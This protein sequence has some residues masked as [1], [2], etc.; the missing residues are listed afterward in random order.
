[1]TLLLSCMIG[2]LFTDWFDSWD[3]ATR[4]PSVNQWAFAPAP[5]KDWSKPDAGGL[6][7]PTRATA[8]AAPVHGD[9]AGPGHS[10]RRDRGHRKAKDN[11]I[12]LR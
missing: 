2:S 5:D 11:G 10:A 7:C 1:M 6:I 8:A 4:M 12:A 3:D 9:R